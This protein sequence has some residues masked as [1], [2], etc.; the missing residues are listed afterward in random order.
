ME[1][2][3]NRSLKKL[4]IASLAAL[5][6]AAL[7][8]G[9]TWAYY[10][11][12]MS[13]VNPLK[14]AHS[15]AALVEEYNPNSSF[16][17]GETVIKDV[18]F[19]NTGEMDIFLRVEVP[20]EEG[21]YDKRGTDKLENLDTNMVI[22]NW[23]EYWDLDSNACLWTD[24]IPDPDTG[25][26]YRYYKKI[27]PAKEKTESIL[28]SIELNT[29]VSNDRHAVDYS[30]KVYKLIFHAE[31]IPVDEDYLATQQE[32]NISVSDDGQGMLIWGAENGD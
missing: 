18:K 17:P 31:A 14:S 9:G 27:L 30:D 15:G 7:S 19:A 10:S 13:I 3:K 23:T 32:W 6:V 25:N 11:D 22:K 2:K 8:F 20:P 5:A 16:L 21:W 24:V 12:T 28:A 4:K 26:G 1:E 29:Q